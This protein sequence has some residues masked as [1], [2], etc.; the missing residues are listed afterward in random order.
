MTYSSPINGLDLYS[1]EF[2]GSRLNHFFLMTKWPEGVP[3]ELLDD[4][5]GPI[6]LSIKM[7]TIKIL[8]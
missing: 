5:F 7:N 6:S 4:N 8:E 1:S 3:Q 2:H